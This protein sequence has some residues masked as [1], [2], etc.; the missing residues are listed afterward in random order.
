MRFDNL[1]RSMMIYM[2]HVY[3][4]IYLYTCIHIM[5]AIRWSFAFFREHCCF[6][7]KVRQRWAE[8]PTGIWNLAM[9]SALLFP[10]SL[11]LDW[12]FLFWKLSLYSC[13]NVVSIFLFDP[14]LHSVFECQMTHLSP[15]SGSESEENNGVSQRLN[16][17]TV[18]LGTLDRSEGWGVFPWILDRFMGLCS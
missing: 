7:N 15:S 18:F 3:I 4:Y 6:A 9:T 12:W 13:H 14:P 5:M 1:M 10:T 16:T 8:E 17:E 2:C 11:R